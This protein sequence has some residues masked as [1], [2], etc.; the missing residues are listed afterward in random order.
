MVA[1]LQEAA[2]D[3]ACQAELVAS[4]CPAAIEYPRHLRTRKGDFRRISEGLAGC[5]PEIQRQVVVDCSE[6]P[7]VALVPRDGVT[8][9][10]CVQLERM[11]VGD[12]PSGA[13]WEYV[14]W[15]ATDDPVIRSLYG[16]LI[17]QRW[18]ARKGQLARWLRQP[19]SQAIIEEAPCSEVQGL[20]NRLER[21]S[22]C[23]VVQRARGCSPDDE[24]WI[25]AAVVRTHIDEARALVEAL[26]RDCP[27]FRDT[28]HALDCSDVPCVLAIHEGHEDALCGHPLRQQ[29]DT[30]VFVMQ[31]P[32]D[33]R[34][35]PTLVVPLWDMG[36]LGTTA[37]A[38]QERYF[39]R[40]WLRKSTACHTV[41]TLR[42]APE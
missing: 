16:P 36:G 7:C 11:P 34:C 14:A 2:S 5:P 24:L 40:V 31:G 22:A 27:A 28:P 33:W 38:V 18:E 21:D 15:A 35:D 12:D 29:P 42:S 26:E 19:P 39:S 1:R 3:P 41:H 25:D 13:D 10:G 8:E 23:E 30:D 4:G 17:D 20:L 9:A 37:P 6:F 32:P